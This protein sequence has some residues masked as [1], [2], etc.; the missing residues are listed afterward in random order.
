MFGSSFNGNFGIPEQPAFPL[1][2]ADSQ[3]GLFGANSPVPPEM[4]DPMASPV[5]P[6]IPP[7]ATPA[8]GGPS[9]QLAQPSPMANPPAAQPLTQPGP[10]QST[11][12]SGMTALGSPF[13][14]S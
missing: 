13:A 7:G 2:G 8:A 4:A 3:G 11:A 5:A 14:R 9:S 6:P 10:S 1:Q 12:A